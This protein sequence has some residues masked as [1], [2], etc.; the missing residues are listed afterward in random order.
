MLMMQKTSRGMQMGKNLMG[1]YDM[2]SIHRNGRK[3]ILCIL[4][5]GVIQEILDLVLQQMV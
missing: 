3:L 5:L 2:L 4:S 1:C